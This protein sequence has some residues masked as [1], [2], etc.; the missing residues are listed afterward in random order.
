METIQPKKLKYR[1]LVSTK[2]FLALRQGSYNSIL[3]KKWFDDYQKSGFSNDYLNDFRTTQ[4][5]QVN[6]FIPINE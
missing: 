6:Y 2:S 3:Y 5:N 1:V 4:G